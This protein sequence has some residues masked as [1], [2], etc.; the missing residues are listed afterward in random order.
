MEGSVEN[1]IEDMLGAKEK[2]SSYVLSSHNRRETL[3]NISASII[4][5]TSSNMNKF[6][7]IPNTNALTTFIHQN[8]SS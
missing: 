1:G 7:E 6:S 8:S 2:K 4:I 3:L 5:T